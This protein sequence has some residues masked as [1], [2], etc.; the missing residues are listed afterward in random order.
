MYFSLFLS[1]A[2][3]HVM[4][5][6]SSLIEHNL[7]SIQQQ[8]PSSL[9]SSHNNNNNNNPTTI[10]NQYLVQS[11]L[12]STE[13]HLFHTLHYIILYSN[14]TNKNLL[15]LNTIELFIYLFI[16]YIHTYLRNNEKEFLANSKL[17][18]GMRLIWQPLFQYHQPNIYIFNS[19]IKPIKVSNNQQEE[20]FDHRL[21]VIVESS[22]EK[23]ISDLTTNTKEDE[24]SVRFI[25][26]DSDPITTI[27][28]EEPIT[29]NNDDNNNNKRIRAPLVH[30]SS[31]CSVTDLTR[32]GTTPQS[33]GE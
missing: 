31:I 19:F 28:I 18:Q 33:P 12:N 3:P 1:K 15:S 26:A 20:T 27:H 29:T 24:K 7:H 13:I 9:L 2:F 14:E 17:N 5:A 30:M 6:C 11:S 25:R 8:N 23:S 32:L 22:T 16:P 4:H 21:S 10:S